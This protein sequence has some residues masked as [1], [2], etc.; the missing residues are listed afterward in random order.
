M[1][2]KR[3]HRD[4]IRKISLSQ[5][6][7]LAVLTELKLS[8]YSRYYIEVCNE[9]RVHL[10]GLAPG[11]HSFKEA[12]QRWLATVGSILRLVLN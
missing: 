8:L 3:R 6:R 4:A 12:L 5:S 10:R 9:W 11:Q 2:T 1:E 7:Q